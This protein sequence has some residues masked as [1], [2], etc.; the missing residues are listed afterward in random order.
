MTV[1][2]KIPLPVVDR[3]EMKV[4]ESLQYNF[5]EDAFVLDRLDTNRI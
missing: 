4:H 5:N 1:Q 2:Y 3:D